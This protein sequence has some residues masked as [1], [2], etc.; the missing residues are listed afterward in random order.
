MRRGL[1]FWYLNRERLVC[2]SGHRRFPDEEG[3]EMVNQRPGEL[4]LPRRHRRF[5]DEEGTEMHYSALDGAAT[6][7][8]SQKIPR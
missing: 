5:P 3:T 6:Y 7:T 4:H 1:K 2:L 8:K